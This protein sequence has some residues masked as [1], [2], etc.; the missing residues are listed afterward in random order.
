MAKSIYSPL[1]PSR[2]VIRLL[3]VE[4]GSHAEDL[5]TRLVQADLDD[6]DR[7]QYEAISYVWGDVSR[8][9]SLKMELGGP[10]QN[11]TPGRPGL[12]DVAITAIRRFFDAAWFRRLWVLQEVALSKRSV[13]HCGNETL[14]LTHVLD[15]VKMIRLT[16]FRS[17]TEDSQ[18]LMSMTTAAILSQTRWLIRCLSSHRHDLRYLISLSKSYEVTD[19]RDYVYAVS[20]Y[21]KKRLAWAIDYSAGGAMVPDFKACGTS[22]VLATTMPSF[23]GD[24]AEVLSVQGISLD[25]VHVTTPPLIEN[26][27]TALTTFLSQVMDTPIPFGQV[28]DMRTQALGTTLVASWQ[29]TPSRKA[30]ESDGK[31]FIDLFTNLDRASG[32]PLATQ[33]G[34]PLPWQYYASLRLA[35]YGRRFFVTRGGFVGLG[36]AKLDVGDEVTTLAG[37]KWPFALRRC[38]GEGDRYKL[39]GTCYVHTVMDGKRADEYVEKGLPLKRYC[40]V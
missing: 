33:S 14:D 16:L 6:A 7:P 18:R 29:F 4:S 5:T 35:C 24:S 20:D 8:R 13:I 38:G 27:D 39:I 19:H 9:A 23:T 21:T 22:P 12:S 3:L 15:L 31:D 34:I 26:S 28:L 11:L 36:P 37:G 30:S 40:I 17:D 1:D 25:V 10:D 32:V 2:K